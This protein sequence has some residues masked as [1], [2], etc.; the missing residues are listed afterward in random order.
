MPACICAQC[1]GLQG[2]DEVTVSNC[3]G[4]EI[5]HRIEAVGFGTVGTGDESDPSGS[6]RCS[7]WRGSGGEGGKEGGGA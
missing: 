1:R 2:G 3:M 6:T 4:G 7:G 5:P